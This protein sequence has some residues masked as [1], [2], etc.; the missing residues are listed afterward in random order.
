MKI[1]AIFDQPVTIFSCRVNQSFG[2]HDRVAEVSYD[3]AVGSYASALTGMTVWVGSTPGAWDVGQTYLRK[4][5][6]SGVLYIGE[7]SEIAWADNLYLTV[8]DEF[9]LWAEHVRISENGVVFMRW[10]TP[11]SDQHAACD[12]V[13]VL[14]ADRAIPFSGTS[15]AVT[16][17]ASGSWAIGSS[18]S[19]HAWSVISGSATLSNAGTSAPTVTVSAAGRVVLRDLL[20]AANGKSRA[21]YR[22]IYFYD[23]TML[24][25][26][27][28]ASWSGSQTR[29]GWEA[30]ISLHSDAAQIRPRAKML[31]INAGGVLFNGWVNDESIRIDEHKG[32]LDFQA[33][34]AAAWLQQMTGFAV[35]LENCQSATPAAWTEMPALTLQRALWHFLAWRTTLTNSLDVTIVADARQASLF[36]APLGNLWEQLR[37]MSAESILAQPLCNHLNQLFVE[38]DSA[39]TPQAERGAIP[40]SLALTGDDYEI[41]EIDWRTV[42]ACGRV[43]LSGIVYSA[44]TATALF[45]LAPGHVFG[46]YGAIKQVDRLLLSTQAQA[47]ELA[48][49]IYA[50]ENLPASLSLKLL[51]QAPNVEIT[52]RARVSI[53]IAAGDSLRGF[54]Y[55]GNLLPRALSYNFDPESGVLEC[56]LEAETETSAGLAVNGDVPQISDA[57]GDLP[58]WEPPAFPPLPSLP[59]LPADPQPQITGL[60]TLV[61]LCSAGLFYTNNLSAATPTWAA[62][63]SGFSSGDLS[64]IISMG[65]LALNAYGKIYLT[66]NTKYWAGTTSGL[67]LVADSTFFLTYLPPNE[68]NSGYVI[69]AVE[70]KYNAPDTVWLYATKS[71][72]WWS[73]YGFLFTGSSSVIAKVGLGLGPAEGNGGIFFQNGK[74]FVLKSQEYM[75]NS[76]QLVRVSGDGKTQEFTNSHSIYPAGGY[77]WGCAGGQYIFHFRR[78]VRYSSDGTAETALSGLFALPN[79]P[80]AVA[81]GLGGYRLMASG[82]RSLDAGTS[83]E[84]PMAPFAS[85]G[86]SIY[87]AASDDIWVAV[88]GSSSL[89]PNKSGVWVTDDFGLTWADKTGNLAALA[90]AGFT[91]RMVKAK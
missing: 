5:P 41:A 34:G 56:S 16:L 83:W 80:Q 63:N 76:A 52:P 87:H 57:G 74:I 35:G 67:T 31:L 19:G 9:N 6:T 28:A 84:V 51:L 85:W 86:G 26:P 3:G 54:A 18:I 12:P 78:N 45:S 47:N 40:V 8:V 32:Q 15:A 14:G 62:L 39:L 24:V 77:E 36:E 23:E 70:A 1:H 27:S 44:G 22:T 79:G 58:A 4:A 65:S 13:P 90:G 59:A 66:S 30:A 38:V 11:Y 55:T 88:N 50:K 72:P 33:Q 17:N 2:T 89:Y 91:P 46:R 60:S 53:A 82:R 61:L 68:V 69:P 37:Q 43:E 71:N 64:S 75:S 29:G 42:P 73:G 49:L 81:A 48:G 25:A 7:G 21:G 10:D 20:T